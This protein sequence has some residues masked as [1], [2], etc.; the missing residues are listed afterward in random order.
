M[1][2]NGVDRMNVLDV[3]LLDAMA[4]EGELALLNLGVQVKVLDGHATLD[5]AHHIALLVRED[6]NRARLVLERRFASH[7]I[8]LHVAQIPHEH[9]S[10]RGGHH[11]F[12]VHHAH[13]V[14]STV[15]LFVRADAL[16]LA[17]VPDL[18]RFVPAARHDAVY[19][20]RVLDA[21]DGA[22]MG[23]EYVL[24]LRVPVVV[25]ECVVQAAA[26][27]VNGTLQMC[28]ERIMSLTFL[29]VY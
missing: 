20:G 27:R 16:L 5:R 22:R 1:E 3:V 24:G 29:A 21:L 4:L 23:A 2:G 11:N 7:Q 8:S 19:F 13:R 15:A 17:R 9:L 26:D 14:Y 12:L 6:A 10:F 18:D 28:V 25:L